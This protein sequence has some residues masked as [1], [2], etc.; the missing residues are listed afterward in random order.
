MFSLNLEK[1]REKFTAGFGDNRKRYISVGLVSIFVFLTVIY[2]GPFG[3]LERLGLIG[4]KK[5]EQ[6]AKAAAIRGS[7]GDLWADLII[8]QPDFSEV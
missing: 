3:G 7:A 6:Q 5:G 4:R 1:R 2:L 8:G